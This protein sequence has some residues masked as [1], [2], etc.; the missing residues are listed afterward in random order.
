MPSVDFE[1]LTLGV[2]SSDED[3]YLNAKIKLLLF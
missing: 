2:A 1:S 3:R